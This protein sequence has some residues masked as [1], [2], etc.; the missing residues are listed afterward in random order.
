MNKVQVK[1]FIFDVSRLSIPVIF[2]DTKNK[3]WNFLSDHVAWTSPKNEI[4]IN[5][6]KWVDLSLNDKYI[7]ILHEIGH[8]KDK[9][10]YYSSTVKREFFAQAW[11]LNKSK[12]LKI[13]GLYSHAKKIFR[14]WEIFFEWNSDHRR[15]VL[16]SRLARKKGL[17]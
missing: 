9:T 15:Y 5:K 16:A 2:C 7:V 17:I 13:K 4:V 11:A 3:E 14:A 12:R 1:K 10:D 8:L 6:V